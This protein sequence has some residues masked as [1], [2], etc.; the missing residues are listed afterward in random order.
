MIPNTNIFEFV[1]FSSV[2]EGFRKSGRNLSSPP[3]DNNIQLKS[4][5]RVAWAN[6]RTGRICN[7]FSRATLYGILI[8]RTNCPWIFH[9]QYWLAILRRPLECV[10]VWKLRGCSADWNWSLPGRANWRCHAGRLLLAHVHLSVMT[11]RKVQNS[12]N[13]H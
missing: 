8:G 10:P 13:L 7:F 11:F 4:G 12:T 2:L 9:C 5:R 1:L 6:F 3:H